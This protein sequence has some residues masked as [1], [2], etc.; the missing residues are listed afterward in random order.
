[1]NQSVDLPKAHNL[2]DL[3][4]MNFFGLAEVVQ[5]DYYWGHLAKIKV[6]SNE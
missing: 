5:D 2:F 6:M 1:M 3:E 4:V